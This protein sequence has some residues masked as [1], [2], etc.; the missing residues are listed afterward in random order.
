MWPLEGT[1]HTLSSDMAR[2]EATTATAAALAKVPGLRERV[3]ESL[4]AI[5]ET[6]QEIRRLSDGLTE[7]EFDAA[8]FLRVRVGNY[9]ISYTLD[10]TLT[11]ATVVFVEEMKSRPPDPEL[12]SK[13][14]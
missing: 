3:E 11:L 1:A 9:M 14:S 12:V 4:L 10:P 8:H 13:A 7:L 2:I 5:L 6:A